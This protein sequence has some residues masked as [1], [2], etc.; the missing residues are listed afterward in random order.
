MQ[1][2]LALFLGQS[3]RNSSLNVKASD[4]FFELKVLD[5]ES[6]QQNLIS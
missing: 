5:L 4:F 2:S 1:S 3:S 6:N